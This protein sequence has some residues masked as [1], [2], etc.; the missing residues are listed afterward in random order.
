MLYRQ[1]NI[2]VSLGV[3]LMVFVYISCAWIYESNETCFNKP[4]IISDSLQ[5]K[6]SRIIVSVLLL[7]CALLFFSSFKTADINTVFTSLVLVCFSFAF[8]FHYKIIH[9]VFVILAI[10]F[11]MC[12]I[13]RSGSTCYN[14]FLK[15][16][17]LFTVFVFCVVYFY[18]YERYS[19]C[20]WNGLLEYFMLGLIFFGLILNAYIKINLYN[21]RASCGKYARTRTL[22]R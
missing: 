7:L 9:E 18:E 3:F 6:S 4:L 16:L 19:P 14:I 13:L 2:L 8:V 5:N 1:T 10:F 20:T 12:V 21:N 17:I 22:F 15:L 11:A